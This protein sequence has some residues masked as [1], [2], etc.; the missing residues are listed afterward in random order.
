MVIIKH[1]V[2][3]DCICDYMVDVLLWSQ[4]INSPVAAVT[5]VGLRYM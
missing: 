1:M 4:Q 2:V 5:Q 3:C